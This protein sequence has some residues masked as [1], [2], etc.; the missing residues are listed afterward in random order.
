[1]IYGYKSTH[2][3]SQQ[4]DKCIVFSDQVMFNIHINDT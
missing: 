2:I 3:C 1:M 4:T